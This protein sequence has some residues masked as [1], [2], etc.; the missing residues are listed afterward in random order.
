MKLSDKRNLPVEYLQKTIPYIEFREWAAYYA[1]ER[2]EFNQNETNIA[3]LTTLVH[4]FISGDKLDIK[5]FLPKTEDRRT[6]EEKEHEII[7]QVARSKSIH[8]AAMG[9][10]SG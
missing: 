3:W 1:V 5:D 7:K 4:N 9:L 8:L 10:K 2:R 6:E